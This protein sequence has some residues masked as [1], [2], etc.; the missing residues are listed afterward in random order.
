MSSADDQLIMAWND[1]VVAMCDR[2]RG[3]IYFYPGAPTFM[4]EMLLEVMGPE[5]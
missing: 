1:V 4:R 3:E 2:V 5:T